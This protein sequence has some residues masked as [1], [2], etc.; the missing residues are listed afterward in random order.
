MNAISK[1]QE[2]QI[3]KK[4][5]KFYR[6]YQSQGSLFVKRHPNFQ[7]ILKIFIQ[8]ISLAPALCWHCGS[9]DHVKV[10][11]MD[12]CSRT[13]QSTGDSPADL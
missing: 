7:L 5:L 4:L 13:P 1:G 12:Q 6:C 3:R 9:P 10:H 8:Q 11:K 2:F